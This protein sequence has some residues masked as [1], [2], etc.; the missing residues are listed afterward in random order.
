[1]SDR[2]CPN[3]G[4][5]VFEDNQRE[6]FCVVCDWTGENDP[7]G[8]A[9][10]PAVVGGGEREVLVVLKNA[11]ELADRRIKEMVPKARFADAITGDERKTYSMSEAA[12][13]MEKRTG[14]GRNTLMQWL[15]DQGF[16]LSTV[17]YWN[18]PS[19][20]AMKRGYAE[21]GE[22]VTP[23]GIVPAPR[24]TGK[25]LQWLERKWNDRDN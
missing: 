2:A 12:K 9:P 8:G 21:V 15:R 16:L 11:L 18:L 5:I 1:M 24:L 10:A 6:L 4:G 25:G 23:K 7:E 20:W 3:C 13:V 17:N 19:D 22:K 14:I